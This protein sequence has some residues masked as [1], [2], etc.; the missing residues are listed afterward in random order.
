MARKVERWQAERPHA[1]VAPA[2][3]Y[4]GRVREAMRQKGYDQDPLYEAV[5]KAWEAVYALSVLSHY[6][7]CEEPN[8]RRKMDR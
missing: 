4:L 7:S 1:G 6:A 2:L 5:V 3:R 8:S